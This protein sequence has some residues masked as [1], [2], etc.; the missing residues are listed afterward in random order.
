MDGVD[1][2]RVREGDLIE[3]SDVDAALLIAEGW[4]KQ[5]GGNGHGAPIDL[6][7]PDRSRTTS[8]NVHRSPKPT[9]ISR[10]SRPRCNRS[11]EMVIDRPAEN[12]SAT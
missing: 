1:V 12:M 10:S 3:L 4:A 5:A 7:I 9:I 2:S 6:V 8:R 11:A